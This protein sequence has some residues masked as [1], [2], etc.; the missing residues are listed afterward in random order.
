[1]EKLEFPTPLFFFFFL[2]TPLPFPT[3]SPKVEGE[4][5]VA[6]GAAVGMKTKKSLVTKQPLRQQLEVPSFLV[7]LPI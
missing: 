5:W 4:V 6:A 3:P 7:H 1:M 2:I